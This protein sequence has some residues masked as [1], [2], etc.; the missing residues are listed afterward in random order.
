MDQKI[1]DQISDIWYN[2]KEKAV[3]CCPGAFGQEPG[4]SRHINGNAGPEGRGN[5]H[6]MSAF[7][8]FDAADVRPGGQGE[9]DELGEYGHKANASIDAGDGE[10]FNEYGGDPKNKI[11]AW[12]AGWN[13]TNAIQVILYD[14]FVWDSMMPISDR[15]NKFPVVPY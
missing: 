15:I 5:S 6:E 10:G 8:S 2:V 3:I 9:Y 7:K 12:Q 14:L 13:V 1:L 11:S 4:E